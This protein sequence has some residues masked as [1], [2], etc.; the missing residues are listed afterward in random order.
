MPQPPQHPDELDFAPLRL[1]PGKAPPEG[2]PVLLF[3]HACREHGTTYLAH[4]EAGAGGGFAGVPAWGPVATW[5]G[6]YAW[7]KHGLDGTHD[8]LQALLNLLGSRVFLDREQV[9]LCGFSRGATVAFGLLAS[10]PAEYGGA[11]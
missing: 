5:G 3:L 1:P 10:R 11:I 2:C 6:G 8:Q 9:F 4:A 7:P